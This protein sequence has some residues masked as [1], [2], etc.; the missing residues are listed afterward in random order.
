MRAADHGGLSFLG[1]KMT[2]EKK[3]YLLHWRGHHEA[4][5][6]ADDEHD[7]MSCVNTYHMRNKSISGRREI[8]GW[9][10]IEIPIINSED[11]K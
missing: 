7:A 2:K 11:Y 6:L 1:D 4:V 8:S 5:V 9:S 10:W 3:A